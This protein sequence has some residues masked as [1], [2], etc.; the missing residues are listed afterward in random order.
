MQI[1]CLKRKL[2]FQYLI[3]NF[4]RNMNLKKLKTLCTV[5]KAYN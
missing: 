2:F 1:A 4:L 5:T 3:N